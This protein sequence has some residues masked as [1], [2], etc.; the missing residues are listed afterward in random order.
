MV[1]SFHDL[2]HCIVGILLEIDLGAN[3]EENIDLYSPNLI[4]GV[5]QRGYQFKQHNFELGHGQPPDKVYD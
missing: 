5:T 3:V 2:I 1:L 4:I